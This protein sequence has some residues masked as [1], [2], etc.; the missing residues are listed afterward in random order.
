MIIS[1]LPKAKS[2]TTTM[3]LFFHVSESYGL[4]QPLKPAP[5]RGMV[6]EAVSMR[7]LAR[8]TNS[9]GNLTKVGKRQ[10][11]Q[12]GELAFHEFFVPCC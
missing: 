6:C 11:F 7:L 10:I 8:V 5:W 12:L 3:R 4:R 1:M 2:R 9:S